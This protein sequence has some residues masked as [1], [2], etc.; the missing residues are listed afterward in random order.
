MDTG[1][2]F[3]YQSQNE[4]IISNDVNEIYVIEKKSDE[5]ILFCYSIMNHQKILE[6]LWQEAFLH[7]QRRIF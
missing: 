6:I 3:Q 5:I 7:Y 4:G 2:F 1:S